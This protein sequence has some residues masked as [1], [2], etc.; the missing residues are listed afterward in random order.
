MTELQ[1]GIRNDLNRGIKKIPAVSAGI[2][3]DLFFINTPKG[4]V[5][6]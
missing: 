6:I 4:H 5:R 1:K 3:I 2:F